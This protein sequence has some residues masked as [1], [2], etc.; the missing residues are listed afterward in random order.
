M[1]QGGMAKTSETG[2]NLPVLYDRLLILVSLGLIA[3]GLIMVASAS[4]M[5]AERLYQQPLYFLYRQ[6]IYA[7]LGIG[8]ALIIFRFNVRFWQRM[9]PTLLISAFFLL[10]LVLIPGIGRQVNGSTRWMMLGPISIQVSEL[11]KVFIIIYL[12]GYL[13]RRHQEVQQ[14][15]KGFIKPMILLSLIC[16]LLLLEPDFGAVVVL[17]ATALG[18]FFLANVRLRYFLLLFATVTA[19]LALLAYVSPYRLQRITAFLHPWA[20]QFDSG[21]QL[22]QALIAFGRGSWMGV[23]LGDSVQKLFYLPEA[24][25]DFLF[26]VLAEELGFFGVFVVL[27]LFA[28]LIGRALFIGYRACLQQQF[29]AGFLA[30]GLGLCL[31]L[32]AII[33]IGVNTGLLPTKGLTLPFISYGGSS[34]LVNCVVVAIILRIDHENRIAKWE[35]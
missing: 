32:E 14:H 21:Y 33:N 20:H 35:K 26:A 8:I 17:L 27:V 25:T 2:I 4:M 7:M 34:M 6:L 31:A 12:S 23:G 10:L 22:T 30:Y 5:V 19:G 13:Q 24:H 1:N 18:L 28:I 16:F 3:I 29:F 11:A 15:I 9:G